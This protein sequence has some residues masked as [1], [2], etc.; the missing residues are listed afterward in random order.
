MT[1]IKEYR[2]ID[3]DRVAC[4]LCESHTPA[5]WCEECEEHECQYCLEAYGCVRL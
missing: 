4:E 2:L 3:F 5:L 1:N